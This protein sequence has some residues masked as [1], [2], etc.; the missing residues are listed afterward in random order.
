M[1]TPTKPV[2]NDGQHALWDRL[3]ARTSA[4]IG[5][6]RVG[7]ALPLDEVLKFQFA[8]AAA[9]DAVHTPLDMAALAHDLAPLPTLLLASAAPDRA[10][11]LRRPDLGRQLSAE[12]AALITPE[13]CDL[14]FVIGDGLSATAVQQHAAPLV[15]A[16]LPELVGLSIGTI[17][18]V[19][20]ARVAVGDP[21]GAAM[22]A[23]MSIV[24]IGERPGLSVADS[25]GIYLTYAPG[26]GRMDSERNCISN[27]HGHGGLDYAAAA[28]TLGWLVR[29]GLKRGLTGI[30]LK[31]ERPALERSSAQ[32]PILPKP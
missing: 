32:P 19:Q 29:E 2:T 27:I 7:T 14:V 6:G 4:R 20:E 3:R 15:R 22:G 13:R 18:L 17:M 12:S 9:R 21:I 1:S 28:R 25:L 23:R 30:G 10:T 5:L 26:P 24:L 31:D 11:Y 16:C 8:H